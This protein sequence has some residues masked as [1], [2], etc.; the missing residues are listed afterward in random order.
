MGR[1]GH[2]MADSADQRKAYV[3]GVFDRAAACYEQTGV[4]FF[5]PAGAALVAAAG[6]GCGLA[7][8]SWTW[9]AAGARVCFRRLTRLAP[10]AP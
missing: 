7:T 10:K 6:L 9:A 3:A 2:V 1:Y 4:R 5:E 8:R